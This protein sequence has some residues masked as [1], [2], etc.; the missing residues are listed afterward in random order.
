MLK[1]F[2]LAAIALATPASAAIVGSLG[3]DPNLNVGRTITGG[4]L[5]DD[6]YTF[7]LDNPETITIVAILNT[8]PLGP[9]SSA[10]IADFTGEVVAGTPALPGVVVIGPE[11]ATSPCGAV[12]NC[13]SLGGI[14]TLAAGDYFLDFSGDAGITAAY[15]GTINTVAAVPEAS[16]WAMMVLGFCSLGW[17]ARR[18]RVFA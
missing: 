2:A 18:R 5:F 8:Y 10:F 14:A 12:A 7:T 9:G 13:Q 1:K 17:L 16:T 3:I 15:G 4:G 6:Q 11:L